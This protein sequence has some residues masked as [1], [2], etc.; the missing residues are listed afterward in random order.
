MAQGKRNDPTIEPT[1]DDICYAAGFIDADGA[2][3]VRAS[4]GNGKRQ[5]KTDPDRQVFQGIYVTVIASQVD[6]RPLMFLRDRWG[7]SIRPLKRRAEGRNDRNAWEWAIAGQLAYKCLHDIGPLLREKGERAENAL[8]LETMRQVRG[9]AALQNPYTDEERLAREDVLN[10]A[11]E[12][13]K[14]DHGREWNELPD[15]Y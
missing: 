5:L 10:V 13:N 11:R 15:S 4:T 9:Y 7:G 14:R 2:I 6:P 1:R 8:R 3:S 12:L